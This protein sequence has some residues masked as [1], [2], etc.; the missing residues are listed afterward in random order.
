MA[1]WPALVAS[2][3]L[4]LSAEVPAESVLLDVPYRSQ[5]DGSPYETANCGPTSVAMLLAFHGIDA[6]PWEIRVRA[7]QAQDSWVDSEG[8]YSDDYGVFIH[9]LAT[10]AESYGLRTEGL[11]HREGF[12]IDRLR[13]WQPADV[14]NA[15]RVGHPVVVQVRYQSLP[16]RSEVPYSGDHY[17]VVHGAEAGEFIYSDPYDRRGGGPGRIMTEEELARAMSEASIPRAAFAVYAPP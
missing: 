4:F 1:I 3:A 2:V 17:I 8:G 10:V 9:H 15:L 16:E 6:S 5:L 14:R 12:R 13:E 11:W 7:M